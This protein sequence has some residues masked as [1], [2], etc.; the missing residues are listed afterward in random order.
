MLFPWLFFSLPLGGGGHN[1]RGSNLEWPVP[2]VSSLYLPLPLTLARPRT[3]D[4]RALLSLQ[5]GHLTHPHI[6]T[7]PS[8]IVEA[9]MLCSLPGYGDRTGVLPAWSPQGISTD[10]GGGAESRGA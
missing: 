7:D 2:R 4:L 1:L 9:P 5:G 3:S 10:L 6:S 8:Q